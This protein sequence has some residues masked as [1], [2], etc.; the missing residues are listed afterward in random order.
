MEQRTS[1]AEAELLSAT[2]GSTE[3]VPSPLLSATYDTT[4][5]VPFPKA[6]PDRCYSTLNIS[7]EAQNYRYGKDDCDFRRN[8]VAAGASGL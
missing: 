2:C 7:E 3:V 5:V 6:H 8:H 4:E 1:A